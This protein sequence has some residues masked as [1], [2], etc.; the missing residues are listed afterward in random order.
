M[1]L[2]V[3]QLIKYHKV[4]IKEL[5]ADML[6]CKTDEA[7]ELIHQCIIEHYSLIIEYERTI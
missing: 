2:E 6:N 7:R 3:K 1:I 4:L 5:R